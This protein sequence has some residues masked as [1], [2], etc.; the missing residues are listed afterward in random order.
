[1]HG[2]TDNPARQFVVTL[3][4]GYRRPRLAD[5]R[6][7]PLQQTTST[8]LYINRGARRE[9]LGV[10]TGNQGA[11]VTCGDFFSGARQKLWDGSALSW[12]TGAIDHRCKQ[13]QHLV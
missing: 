7:P 12:H 3:R 1:M 11:C 6:G 2:P 9:R 4:N 5:V 13:L 10:T 8:V